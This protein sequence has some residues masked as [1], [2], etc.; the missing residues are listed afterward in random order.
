VT[1]FGKFL[2]STHLDELGQLINILR[3]DISFVGPR[4][5]RPEFV[6]ELSESIPH[7]QMRHMI[8][9]GLTGWAQI[10]FRY[11]RNTFDAK[12]KFEYDL[13][14]LKNRSLLLDLAIIAKT[15]QYVFIAQE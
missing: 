4:P 7:Y 3:G 1:P 5:E 12:E 6:A 13:Y 15:A 2:R 10:K 14:Y 11:A 9:P 8:T